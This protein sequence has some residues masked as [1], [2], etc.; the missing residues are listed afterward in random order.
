MDPW[1]KTEKKLNE[2]SEGRR[3]RDSR[4]LESGKGSQGRRKESPDKDKKRTDSPEKAPRDVFEIASK[5]L[6]SK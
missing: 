4:N 2:G 5:T 1:N 6:N 3:R